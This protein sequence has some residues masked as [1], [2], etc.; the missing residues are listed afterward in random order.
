MTARVIDT[1]GW[2][3]VKR[4]PLSKVGIYPYSGAQIGAAE[5]DRNKIF[6]VFR[7]PEELGAPE[8]IESFKLVPLID[9]HTMLGDGFTPAEQKGVAGVIGENVFFENDT[10][11]GNPKI[12]SSALAEKIKNGKTELSMGYRCRYDFTPGFWNGQ[13][14]DVVQRALRGNHVAL[15]N[16]GRM[17]PEVAILDHLMVITVDA[18]ET[19]PVD[20]DLKAA[21]AAIVARLDKLEAA[22]ASEDE[23]AA[24]KAADEEAAKKAADEDAEAKKAT[25]EEAAK[26]AEDE[27]A[28]KDEGEEETPTS[29]DAALKKI[30]LLEGRLAVAEKRPAMDEADV[31]RAAADKSELVAKLAPLVGTFDHARMTG[32]QVA[33]YGV[34]KL[35]IKNVP[36]GGE[37]VALDAYLQAAKIPD[38]TKAVRTAADANATGLA[39]SIVKHST[40]A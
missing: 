8:T 26:K 28:A 5:A 27:E 30:A 20:E 13:E 39:A 33:A 31:V 12:Y 7:P 24:K 4:N 15:V 25:D 14:Y 3:E 6:R 10:L 1:N 17:G 16:E 40:G 22:G 34:E 38:P 35:G 32:A 21:L 11:Y 23:E 37:R 36:K 19:L 2:F 18:K 9:D 29:M